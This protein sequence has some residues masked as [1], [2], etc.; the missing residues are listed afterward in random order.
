MGIFSK[1]SIQKYE[2]LTF[3]YNV[4][5]YGCVNCG[6]FSLLILTRSMDS[7]QA[8]ECF[9][10]EPNCIGFIG[11]KTQTDI[12]AMDDLYLDALGITDEAD[13]MELKGTKKKKGKKI[14]DPDFMVRVFLFLAFQVFLFTPLAAES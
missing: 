10:G 14:D 7:H 8:Q 3:N 1:R 11:G 6:F 2:E 5:R 4:D 9:C 12:A 13:L